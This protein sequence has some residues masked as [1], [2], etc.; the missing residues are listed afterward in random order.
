MTFT[1]ALNENYMRLGRHIEHDERSWAYRLDDAVRGVEIANVMWQNYTGILDQ[2]KLGACVGFATDECVGT[3]QN[4]LPLNSS[5]AAALKRNTE[6]VRIYSKATGLD[7]ITGSY[8]P[9]DTGSTGI[10]GAKAAVALGYIKGYTHAFSFVA[11]T[12]ALMTGPLIVGTNWYDSMFSP[13]PDGGVEISPRA[14]VVG[15]HEYMVYGYQDGNFWCQQSWGK[16]FGKA[17]KFYLSSLTMERLLG[18]KGD[19][20][21]FI[22]LGNPVPTPAP[23]AP[24]MPT[25]SADDVQLWITLKIWADKKGLK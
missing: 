14:S 23:P 17:G 20:T 22:P 11:M 6:A 2:A 13:N 12:K 1:M 7:N 5:Q 8:P 4:F 15:G 19:A 18:E 10:A 9:N 25:P 21:Q 3:G 24:P 16:S